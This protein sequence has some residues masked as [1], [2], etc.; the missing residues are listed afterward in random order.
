M[1]TSLGNRLKYYRQRCNLTLSNV[2]EIT[3][4]HVTTISSYERGTREP[5]H[6]TLRLLA[7]VYKVNVAFLFLNEEELNELL[8]LN[9]PVLPY[10]DSLRPDIQELLPVLAK[11]KPQ[12]VKMLRKFLTSLLAAEE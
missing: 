12:S 9:H 11:L 8:S 4:L 7:D 2:E 3:G 6:R 5:S 10:M 1:N